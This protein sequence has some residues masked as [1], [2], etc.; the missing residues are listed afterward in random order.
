[1][2]NKSSHTLLL[3]FSN[4]VTKLRDQ[5]RSGV[6]H[7][8]RWL[9]CVGKN[10]CLSS[11]FQRFASLTVRCT[12]HADVLPLL[13]L[14]FHCTCIST[15][16]RPVYPVARRVRRV[17]VRRQTSPR[18]DHRTPAPLVFKSRA[19]PKATCMDT[20]QPK[21]V[22]DRRRLRN[23]LPYPSVPTA[24]AERGRTFQE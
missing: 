9:S 8:S 2:S 15:P 3:A 6:Y 10:S 11:D 7:L 23:T 16:R 5:V 1:V 22:R 14:R 24:T 17:R 13:H 18:L 4:L 12:C 19:G 20:P 21:Q